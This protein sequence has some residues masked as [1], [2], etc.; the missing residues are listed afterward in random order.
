MFLQ[1]IS[2]FILTR[3]SAT[4]CL[5]LNESKAFWE[6]F[7]GSNQHNLFVST[8][9]RTFFINEQY[10]K[11]FGMLYCFASFWAR[12]FF[13]DWMK[14]T[15]GLHTKLKGKKGPK[16]SAKWSQFVL[17]VEMKNGNFT[18]GW[19]DLP[20][21]VLTKCFILFYTLIGASA[22][23]PATPRAEYRLMRPWPAVSNVTQT[24]AYKAITPTHRLPEVPWNNLMLS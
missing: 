8:T 11:S 24:I 22:P 3:I 10:T 9:H 14:S 12:C 20:W 23:D 1:I 6:S 17:S 15:L 18:K 16:W 21:L 19:Q 13:I 2:S 7:W 5:H 4:I